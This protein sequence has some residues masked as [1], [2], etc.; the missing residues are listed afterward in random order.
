MS[1]FVKSIRRERELLPGIEK[2]ETKILV[3]EP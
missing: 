2:P 1:G 3:G